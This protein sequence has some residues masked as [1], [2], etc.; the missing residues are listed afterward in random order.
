LKGRLT[1]HAS[2]L[3]IHDLG[4]GAA[5]VEYSGL[6]DDESN[7]RAVAGARALE[8]HSPEG[9]LSAVV[10]ARTLFLEFDPA[11]CPVDRIASRLSTRESSRVAAPRRTLR[12]PV[13]YGEEAG[14]ELPELASAAGLAPQEF[15]RRHTAAVYRVAFLGF[16]PGFAYLAGLP[17]ELQAPR[18]STP[19]PRVGAGTVAIAGPYTGIYPGGTPGG[20]RSIG[21]THARLFDPAADPP[22][23]FLP[24][25]EVRFERVDSERLLSPL[26]RPMVPEPQGPTA[27]T[28]LFRVATPGVFSSV[29]GAPRFGWSSYGVPPGG[30]MDWI[31]RAQANARLGNSQDDAALEMTLVGAE[32]ETLA[33]ATICLAGSEAEAECNGRPL[34]LEETIS[35]RRG[36]RLRVGRVRGGMR[37]YLAVV[38]GFAPA[39][40]FEISQR[41]RAGDLLLS[42]PVPPSPRPALRSSGSLRSTSP[43]VS[44]PPRVPASLRPRVSAPGPSRTE[45]TVVRVVLD[46]RDVPFRE[47]GV[48]TFLSSTY[49]VS[50]S[51]DR[52][53]VRLE[54]E[55]VPLS[56]APDIPPEGTPLG[57]IQVARDGMP[58]V[59]GPD[60][61][62]TG[63]YAR[64]ATVIHADF[65][66]LAQRPPG[67]TLRFVAVSLAEALAA[68]VG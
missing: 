22:T 68:R 26:E 7:A 1:P 19:R 59:L 64:I 15:A 2:R 47:E 39:G 67:A 57:G 63:G 6:S 28:A 43:P 17:P 30:A 32:L 9:L 35:V 4:D 31:A 12:I 25:D 51:S 58:I 42:A 20:W 66:L 62:V 36:D 18:L 10:G 37:T 65:P 27:G 52:R 56:R 50:A 11:K 29:Q 13:V 8:R 41:L 46:P 55:P 53:G 40:R 61:P 24:G 21:W 49:R 16:A 45:E 14:S 33:D 34:A 23:L 38:G 54:G 5:L 44:S 3:T 60:R 48:A